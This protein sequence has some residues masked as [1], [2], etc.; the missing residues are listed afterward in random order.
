MHHDQCAELAEQTGLILPLGE[1]LLRVSCGQA[2]W[3]HKGNVGDL[4]LS[5]GLTAHQSADADLV[6]RVVRVLDYTG[7]PADRLTVGMPI[8]ALRVAEAADSLTVLA[9]MGVRTSL[10]DFGLSPDDLTA[11]E[12]FQVGAVRVARRLTDR[13]L[14]VGSTVIARLVT[15]VHH[16]GAT[17]TVDGIE[18]QEQVD[19]WRAAG[20]DTAT[21]DFFGVVCPP[22]DIAAGFQ[23]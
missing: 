21:G 17:V 20:A 14:G 8:A 13:L 11:V 23:A 15:A 4:P 19:W 12:E 1:W 22:G 5:V 2:Y 16:A 6:S 9:D 10:D 3:W 18:T 7:L